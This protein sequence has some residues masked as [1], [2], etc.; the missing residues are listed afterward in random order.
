MNTEPISESELNYRLSKSNLVNRAALDDERVRAALGTA[1]RSVAS[2]IFATAP[3]P[4]SLF[5]RRPTMLGWLPS[6]WPWSRSWATL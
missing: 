2:S 3:L 5:H 1:M 6:L 4:R